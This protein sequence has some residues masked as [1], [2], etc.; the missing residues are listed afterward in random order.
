M[1]AKYFCLSGKSC[2]DI[3]N[4]SFNKRDGE[5]MIDPDGGSNDDAL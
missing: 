1:K 3:K 4:K 2:R 5:Y